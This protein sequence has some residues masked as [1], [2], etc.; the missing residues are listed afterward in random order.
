VSD[1]AVHPGAQPLR[2]QLEA[3]AARYHQAQDEYV[4]A[5][6]REGA[7][8][9]LEEQLVDTR[10]EFERLLDADVA[11]AEVRREWGR[12]LH[13]RTPLPAAP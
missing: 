9:R 4:H 10:K 6:T 1:G 5:S 11:D 2:A 12:H 3:L 7:R 13:Y 8:R